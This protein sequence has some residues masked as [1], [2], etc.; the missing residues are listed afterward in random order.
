MPSPSLGPPWLSLSASPAFGPCGIPPDPDG[1][2]GV[3][4][5]LAVVGV[6]AGAEV[7]AVWGAGCTAVV[8]GAGAGVGVVAVE[9][10]AGW[11]ALCGFALW[12]L[13]L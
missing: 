6:G 7:V 12:V 4:V 1:E 11:E 8:V 9:G 5:E 13:T 3:V 10:A 2:E